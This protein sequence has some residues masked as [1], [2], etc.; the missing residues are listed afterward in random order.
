MCGRGRARLN[1]RQVEALSHP[2]RLRIMELFSRNAS[3]SLAVADLAADLGDDF[4]DVSLSKVN[5]H[6]R[7][8]QDVELIPETGMG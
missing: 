8:L 4:K 1:H 7:H 5:Y 2:I 3:R 6:L